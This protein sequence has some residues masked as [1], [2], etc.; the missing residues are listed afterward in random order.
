MHT[1]SMSEPSMASGQPMV[2][3]AR[4]QH[5]LRPLLDRLESEPGAAFAS[6]R[7]GDHFVDVTVKEVVET[8]RKVA[9]V[10]WHRG[11]RRVIGSRSCHTPG[12]NG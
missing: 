5:L 12:S 4:D 6:R 11:S 3:L 1:T 9:G 8:I 2:A 7:E 10:S